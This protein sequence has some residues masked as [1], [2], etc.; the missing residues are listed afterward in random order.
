MPGQYPAAQRLSNNGRDGL[1]AV[2]AQPDPLLDAIQQL[3]GQAP[4]QL[5]PNATWYRLDPPA[6]SPGPPL[7][8]PVAAA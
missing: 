3:A 2:Q 8:P 7:P 4:P 6:D 1:T 5:A